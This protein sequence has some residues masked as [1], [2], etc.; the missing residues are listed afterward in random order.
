MIIKTISHSKSIETYNPTTGL[1]TWYNF[2]MMGELEEG[3]SRETAIAKL[4]N[5]VNSAF[6]AVAHQ[7]TSPAYQESQPTID[8][9]RQECK[10]AIADSTTIPDLESLFE[11]ALKYGLK[12]EYNKRL[13]ELS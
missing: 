13:N 5:E 11:N 8:Y 7:S 2:D 12:E 1:K 6:N 4:V 3:E 10:D 9:K